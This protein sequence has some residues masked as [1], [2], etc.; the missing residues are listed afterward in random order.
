MSET[1]VYVDGAYGEMS[2]LRRARLAKGAIDISCSALV[3]AYGFIESQIND[4]IDNGDYE[5]AAVWRA[6]QMNVTAGILGSGVT[7]P[8]QYS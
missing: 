6:N 8:E 2:D 3:S 7:Q 1:F 5:Q 4:A